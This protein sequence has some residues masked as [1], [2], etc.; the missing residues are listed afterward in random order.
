MEA[1]ASQTI[2]PRDPDALKAI[3]K[4]GGVAGAVDFVGTGDS[5]AMGL[6]ALRKGG[7]M[8]SVGLIGGATPITPA[9]IAS[10]HADGP[11]GRH[12]GE[13]RELIALANTGV[14]PPLPVRTMALDDVNDVIARL[15]AGTFPGRAVLLPAG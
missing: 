6:N 1:G 9:M 2:D 10:P 11:D 7:K 13:L 8:V 5:F 4:A 3:A 12:G 15:H 14:L